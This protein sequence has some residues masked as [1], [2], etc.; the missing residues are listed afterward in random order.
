MHTHCGP[1]RRQELVHPVPV[2]PPGRHCSH[3]QKSSLEAGGKKGERAE[4]KKSLK[5]K[6]PTMMEIW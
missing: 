3:L 6:N 5:K 1:Q 4:R 2:C